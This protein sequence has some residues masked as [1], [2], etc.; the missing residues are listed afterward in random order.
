MKLPLPL[1]LLTVASIDA[2]A[3]RATRRSKPARLDAPLEPAGV[4]EY[5]DLP[6]ASK[7]T[8]IPVGTLRK[9]IARGDLPAEKVNGRH[10]RVKVVDLQKLFVPVVK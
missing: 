5:E 8:K 1:L 7:R 4:D 6:G 10:I 3:N 2:T 9:W